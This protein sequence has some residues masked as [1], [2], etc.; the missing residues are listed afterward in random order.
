MSTIG[1]VVITCTKY[2]KY[3]AKVL[4]SVR[5]QTVPHSL[6]IVRNADATLGEAANRGVKRLPEVDYIVRVDGDDWIVPDLLEIEQRYLDEHPE[7]D[8][9]WCDT[10]R[11]HLHHQDALQEVYLIEPYREVSLVNTCGAMYRRSCWEAIGGYGDLNHGENVDFW[12]RFREA[13]FVAERLP[14]PLYFY[15]QHMDNMHHD[16]EAVRAAREKID[17]GE[18]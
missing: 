6:A 10:M 5:S 4:E 14:Q 7:V 8:C 11:A 16:T 1:V 3:L 18:S 15:R 13:G 2:E 12:K 9:V 17:G